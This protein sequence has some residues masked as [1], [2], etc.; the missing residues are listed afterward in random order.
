MNTLLVILAILAVI[1]L[2]VGGI[3]ALAA[4]RKLATPISADMTKQTIKDDLEWAKSV[5]R[6]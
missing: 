5:G 2:I 6:G 3:V 4:R 1:L